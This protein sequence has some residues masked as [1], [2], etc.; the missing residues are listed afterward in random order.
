MFKR[1]GDVADGETFRTQDGGQFLKLPPVRPDGFLWPFANTLNLGNRR[2][3]YLGDQVLV[4]VTGRESLDIRNGVLHIETA[5]GGERLLI[6][7]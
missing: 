6:G 3:A 2:F 4:K 7:A 5:A 1:F